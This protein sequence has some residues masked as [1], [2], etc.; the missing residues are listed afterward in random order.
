[1]NLV[2]LSFI[3]FFFLFYFRHHLGIGAINLK[4]MQI[5]TTVVLTK[6]N[7]QIMR[8]EN[9]PGSMLVLRWELVLA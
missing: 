5:L 6:P 4:T 7:M 9:S 1:M 3:V 2:Y 8:K